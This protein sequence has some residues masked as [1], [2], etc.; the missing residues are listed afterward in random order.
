[1]LW[2]SISVP[3]NND[4]PIGHQMPWGNEFY[5]IYVILRSTENHN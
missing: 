3:H 1:M 4:S 5:F 2:T